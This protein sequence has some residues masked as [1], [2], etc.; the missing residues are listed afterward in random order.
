M[1]AVRNENTVTAIDDN[2]QVYKSLELNLRIKPED[3][4]VF[5][6]LTLSETEL[7]LNNATFYSELVYNIQLD[8]F[9]K[10]RDLADAFVPVAT[11]NQNKRKQDQEYVAIVEGAHFPFFAIAFSIQRIQFNSHL[12]IDEDVD[13]SKAAVR[14]AQRMGNLFVDEARLS[15]NTFR[16]A[17]DEYKAVIENYDAKVLEN[18]DQFSDYEAL[19]NG[20]M[21]LF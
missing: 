5:D 13:H 2:E 11:F 18:E 3:S 20:E 16:L 19:V 8:K 4:Y 15:G 17:S 6:G 10:E 9:L 7:W 1:Q 12:Q 21:Y 14:M